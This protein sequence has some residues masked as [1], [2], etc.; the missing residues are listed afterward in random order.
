MFK[1]QILLRRKRD[2]NIKVLAVLL[3]IC[4]NLVMD[5]YNIGYTF[6][7]SDPCIE[8]KTCELTN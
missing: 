4:F 3:K 1:K 2:G 7:S 6:T 5:Y 8:Y